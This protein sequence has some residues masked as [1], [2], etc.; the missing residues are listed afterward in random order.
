MQAATTTSSSKASR[1]VKAKAKAVAKKPTKAPAKAKA[2]VSKAKKTPAKKTEVTLHPLA[3]QP[4][5]DAPRWRSPEW[6]AERKAL[7]IGKP[8]RQR[9]SICFQ[10]LPLDDFGVD[11]ATITG[12]RGMCRPCG[13][14]IDAARTARRAKEAVAK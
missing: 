12:R 4:P 1:P 13:K 2:A 6:T 11:S 9:C 5:K 7:A 10:V 3:A 8:P 14:A